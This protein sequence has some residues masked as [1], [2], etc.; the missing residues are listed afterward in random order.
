M[1]IENCLTIG[2][3]IQEWVGNTTTT[4]YFSDE[5]MTEF[6]ETGN[7]PSHL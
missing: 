1:Y 5:S 3:K 7:H 2:C 6:K 4:L